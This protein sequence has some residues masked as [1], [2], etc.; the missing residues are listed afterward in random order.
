MTE[1]FVQ[2]YIYQKII[3]V[4]AGFKAPED[5]IKK[6]NIVILLRAYNSFGEEVKIDF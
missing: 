3:K 6:E 4:V 5:Q 1:E 2:E